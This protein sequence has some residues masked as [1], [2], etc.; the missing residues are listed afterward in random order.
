M[1]AADPTCPLTA[2]RPSPIATIRGYRRTGGAVVT[3]CRAGR[4]HRHRITLRRYALLR[5]WT[6]THAARLWRTSGWWGRSSI[7]VSLWKART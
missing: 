6:V 4:I 2:E 1:A 3:V 5:K 7:A